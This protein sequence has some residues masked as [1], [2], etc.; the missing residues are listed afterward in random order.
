MNKIHLFNYIGILILTA[1]IVVV[2]MVLVAA[3]P[4]EYI[5]NNIKTSSKQLDEIGE[6]SIINLRF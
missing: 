2:L 6:K 1:I 3:I 4:R 5:Q